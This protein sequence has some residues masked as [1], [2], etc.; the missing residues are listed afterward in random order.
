MS[1]EYDATEFVDTDFQEHKTLTST[2]PSAAGGASAGSQAPRAP[3]REEVDRKVTETHKKLTELKRAQEELEREKAALEETRRRQRECQAGRQ[4]MITH[5][6]RGLGLLE[7]AEFA[8]RRD[9]EQMA[10][11]LTEFRNALAQ[12]QAINEE[13]WTKD[14]FSIELTRALTTVENARMEL[15]AA[16]LKFPLLTGVTQNPETPPENEDKK[17]ASL[18]ANTNF[19]ELCKLGLAITWPVATVVALALIVLIALLIRR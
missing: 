15:N 1:A 4:E 3:T 2:G 18:L 9:A 5:L 8:A 19:A 12:V 6:T 10:K 13:G 14:N 16:R 11:T 17:P 7:K